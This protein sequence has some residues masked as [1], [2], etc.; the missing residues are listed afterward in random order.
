M[1]IPYT[2][3]TCHLEM[4]FTYGVKTMKLYGPHH[5]ASITVSALLHITNA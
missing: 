2:Q 1:S 4:N 5:M 3:I